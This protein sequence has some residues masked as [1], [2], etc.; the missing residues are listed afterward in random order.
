MTVGFVMLVHEALDR[1]AEVARR[2]AVSG[3]PVVI[4]VDARVPD[5]VH[6]AFVRRTQGAG[7]VRFV[8]RR[9]CEWGTWSLVQASLDG[10]ETM[11]DQFG[12]VTHV[13]L[14]SGACL[15][16]RP[17]ADLEAYLGRRPGIDFIESVTIDDV[18]WAKGGLD[19]ERFTLTFPFP[20]KRQRALFDGWVA[21]QRAV[22]RQR[23]LPDG[24]RPHLG[25][26]WWCLTRATLERLLGDDRRGRLERWFRSVWIPDE[27]YFQTLARHYSSRIES[28]SLTLSEF[29]FQGKPHVFYD[30]HL[31]L[32][33]DSR[34]FVAR[35]IWPRA[36]KL[37]ATFPDRV[38]SLGAAEPD[39][40]PVHRHF[41]R[42]LAR[43]T[44][45]R[46]GLCH[47]GRHPNPGWG[48]GRTAARYAVFQGFDAVVADFAPW[49]S[50][51][52]GA[53][54][55]GRLFALDRV[56]F[57]DGT[58]V[59][60]GAIPATPRTRDADPEA[61]V[62][63][64]IWATRGEPQAF[65]FHPADRQWVLGGVLADD[66]NAH[67]YVVTGAWALDLYRRGLS[68]AD[69]R[70]EAARLQKAEAEAVELL[71]RPETRA[72]TRIWSLA[73][74]IEAPM[75]PLQR[76]ARDLAPP[77]DAPHLVAAP[78]FVPMDGFGVFLQGLRNLG[79]NPYA[80]GEIEP[81]A[82]G[83]PTGRA[84]R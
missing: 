19:H 16:L 11:L 43:R 81:I 18:P 27:S 2:W 29:D 30:D 6:A 37:Y 67:I 34:A 53:R 79:M 72:R 73:E 23:R 10:A 78:D 20:W 82:T 26:Q 68:P 80:A 35:K 14:A 4:H 25:S 28:R 76:I 13:Y 24:I 12:D 45:G 74:M 57:A 62:R 46:A 48:H 8:R 36:G 7:R 40:T 32:L 1:A 39:A 83:V 3:A 33:R 58:D 71:R 15:P 75:E 77:R 51:T 70:S 60:P 17:L 54:C 59:A 69:A 56:E 66:P 64:L 61:F 5:D 31:P 41:R 50:R 47:S 38:P 22:G 65:H 52:V 21:A 44:E 49:L 63:N 9:A 42:A 55:H 84:V